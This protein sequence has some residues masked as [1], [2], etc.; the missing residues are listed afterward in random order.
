MRGLPRYVWPNDL[1]PV[2][3]QHLTG[4]WLQHRSAY[5]AQRQ[6]LD[7]GTFCHAPSINLNFDQSGVVTACCY[8]RKFVLGTYPRDTLQDIWNGEKRKE[9]ERY[10]AQ[11][12]LSHGCELCQQQLRAGNIAGMRATYFQS[13]NVPSSPGTPW[14]DTRMPKQMEFEL[15][16]VCN[17]EC[18]MCSGHFSSLIRQN[19]EHLPPLVN[20]YDDAFVEQLH[21]FL[22]YLSKVV[23]AGG[24]PFLNRL[25]YKIW[26][27]MADSPH[28]PQVAL[29][30][31]GTIL[32][33]KV[34]DIVRK[35]RID[36][37]VSVDSLDP[38][39]YEE[40]RV[41]ADYGKLRRNLDWFLASAR[42]TGAWFGF[43]I[44]TMTHNWRHVPDLFRFCIQSDI[45]IFCNTVF[46]PLKSSLR[47][48]PRAELEAVAEFLRT[49][50]LP[51][52]KNRVYARCLQAYDDL[53]NQVTDWIENPNLA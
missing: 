27:M 20:P 39:N 32:N 19:R 25:Y 5:D 40:I 10:L 15:S 18:V 30:T 47:S 12:D 36:I 28:Q 53:I 51:Q 1:R 14:N 6:P 17:L 7:R 8:N 43:S 21:P 9:L 26:D 35:L 38:V 33:D 52:I 34:K 4:A 23:F 44:C 22:R 50:E 41:N 2:E 13:K 16:N 45:D 3:D 49:S 31:N 29:V 48:L 11:D 46:W 42:E 37:A 24:E